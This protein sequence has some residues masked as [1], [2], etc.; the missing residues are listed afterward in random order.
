MIEK[1]NRAGRRKADDAVDKLGQEIA[2][3]RLLPGQRLPTEATLGKQLGISRPSLREALRVLSLKGLVE[4]RTRRGTT[5]RDQDRWDYLDHDV[6]RWMVAGSGGRDLMDDLLA[7]RRIFEP[8]AARL[9]AQRATDEQIQAIETAYEGMKASLPRD[10]RAG[11]DYDLAFHQAIADATGNALLSCLASAIRTA[12]LASFKIGAKACASYQRSLRQ[13]GAVVAAIR[14]RAP[15]AAERKMRVLLADT[16]GDLNVAMA[17]RSGSEI[18]KQPQT[19][20]TRRKAH[21]HAQSNR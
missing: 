4:S 19:A 10:L 12:L 5:V 17:P 8:P 2:S 6:L 11:H 1:T 20:S 16:E 15:V 13:H 14:A 21:D 7:V 18:Q 9:A 3:C